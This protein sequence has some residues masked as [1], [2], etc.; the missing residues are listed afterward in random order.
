ML[1]CLSINSLS[2]LAYNTKLRGMLVLRVL[3]FTSP[4]I[5]DLG[6]L[7]KQT[8]YS[9]LISSEYFSYPSLLKSMRRQVL[10]EKL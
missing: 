8:R 4:Q 5:S 10:V 2:C 1:Y 6:N 7:S 9:P 3:K